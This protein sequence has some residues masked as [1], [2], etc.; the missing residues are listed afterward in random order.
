MTQDRIV[1]TLAKHGA[2]SIEEL[3]EL[4]PDMARST[5][6]HELLRLRRKGAIVGMYVYRL[7]EDPP[8]RYVCPECGAH[9]SHI[10]ANKRKHP[11]YYC[12]VCGHHF[13]EFHDRGNQC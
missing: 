13:D 8:W 1:R 2:L 4:L 12:P 11:L 5:I 10:R 9:R 6:R 3:A 7:K